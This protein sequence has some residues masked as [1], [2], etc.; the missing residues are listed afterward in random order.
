MSD[1]FNEDKDLEAAMIKACLLF[2]A[3]KVQKREMLFHKKIIVYILDPSKKTGSVDEIFQ[4]VSKE[5]S[6]FSFNRDLVNNAVN[7]LKAD[8]FIDVDKD[9]GV[10]L[11]EKTQAKSDQY[12]SQQ[13]S[14]FDKLVDSIFLDV[15]QQVPIKNELQVKQNI[16]NCI[17]YYIR[18]SCYKTLGV[19][20][21]KDLDEI[22][23]L[24]T[25]AV[26]HLGDNKRL[27]EQ[28]L[29]SIGNVIAHPTEE[30]HTTLDTMARSLITMQ[31][32]ASDPLLTNFKHSVIG[33]KV[34]VLDTDFVLYLITDNG[35]RSVQYKRLL[36][37][38]T[39]CNCKIYIPTEVLTEIFDHAEAATKKYNFVRSFIENGKEQ[40]VENG[41]KNI[42][43]EAYY[44]NKNAN[45]EK[46]W[47]VFI[48]NYY[49]KERGCKYTIDVV[50]ECLS[51]YKNIFIGSM[52][53][54]NDIYDSDKEED[55]SLRN[56]LFEKALEATHNTEKAGRRDEIKNETIARTDTKLYL[57]VRDLNIKE[58][59]RNGNKDE[60][61]DLLE[62]KYYVITNTFRI[63]P[64]AAEL[65]LKEKVFCT[66]M[67]MMAYMV[68]AGFYD[69][70]KPDVLSLFENTFFAYIANESWDDTKNILKTGIDFNGKSIVR[71]RYDLQD[72]IQKLLTAVPGSDDYKT[73]VSEVKNKGYSFVEPIEYTHNLEKQNADKDNRIAQ[74][75]AE[76][77]RLKKEKGKEKY[78][79]RLSNKTKKGKKR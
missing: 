51:G 9:G 11:T 29:L 12:I 61:A 77:N 69:E 36:K 31:L 71:L 59:E 62:Y 22:A 70:N 39:N 73:N 45:G 75:E 42:F 8:G 32:L 55:I 25:K 38:L 46:S 6:G 15:K 48:S 33:R 3:V 53:Y 78:Q 64:C 17:D 58:R 49:D 52:P 68:E 54:D 35:E 60:R 1:I 65:N 19:D 7:A 76:I 74:L 27:K 79:N 40:W 28:I 47:H 41:I 44:K 37:V 66:P 10:S 4:L 50:K 24:Q 56:Q 14:L 2:D 23:L 72:N 21:G 43:V 5:L 67:A 18:V 13:K 20:E 63:Y 57:S 26:F 34:F 16:K 30:Q